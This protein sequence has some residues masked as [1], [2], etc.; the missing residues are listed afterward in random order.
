MKVLIVD[1]DEATR[2]IIGLVIERLGHETILAEDGDQGLLAFETNK[3]DLVFTDL[4]MPNMDGLELLRKIRLLDPQV[5]VI[6]ISSLTSPEYTLAAL[7]LKANDYLIKPFMKPDLLAIMEKYVTI[8]NSRVQEQGI[9]DSMYFRELKMKISNRLDLVSG[10]VHQLMRETGNAIQEKDRLGVH[11]GLV[12]LISNAIE[13]GNLGITFDEKTDS[14][15]SGGDAWQRLVESRRSSPPYRDRSVDLV[16]R[17]TPESCEWVIS[18]QGRGF[19]WNDL[20]DPC[21]PENLL[22]LHGRGIMLAKLQFDECT[23]LGCGN[24]VRLTKRLD[25]VPREIE[26]PVLI[27]EGREMPSDLMDDCWMELNSPNQ[28]PVSSQCNS[29]SHQQQF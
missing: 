2:T 22:A 26:P 3:P 7:H 10:V 8:H 27:T 20:P 11:L 14:L 25:G 9:L 12:E 19:V 15:E 17:M 1:D 4:Q 5:L 13:H 18:D 6:I 28:E 24:Q 16:F 29:V 23:Y 21:Q